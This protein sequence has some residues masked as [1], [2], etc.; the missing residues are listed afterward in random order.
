M[1]E[2]ETLALGSGI[3][4]PKN[5]WLEDDAGGELAVLRLRVDR[6]DTCVDP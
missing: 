6:A 2:V 4:G 5:C 1:A 3:D